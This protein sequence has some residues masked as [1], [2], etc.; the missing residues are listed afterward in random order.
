M[1]AELVGTFCLTTVDA[2]GAMIAAFSTQVTPPAR[3]AAAGLLVMAMVYALSNVSGAHFNPMVTLGFAL[4]RVFPLRYVPGYWAAQLAG[5]VLGASFLVALFGPFAHAGATLP[6]HGDG[7][8]VAMEAFLT[9]LLVTVTL[10]VATRHKVVG[11]TAALASGGTVALCGLFARPISG[12]SMNPARSFG[13]FLVTWSFEHSWVYLVGP[14]AG[15]IAGVL[16]VSIVHP[17]KHVEE[18]DAA[19]GDSHKPATRSRHTA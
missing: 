3:A 8:A 14:L 4:R 17:R 11:P 16:C 13:P 7:K 9:F 1:T 5:A 2:G 18:H 10:S 15:A 12:A 6:G 19:T